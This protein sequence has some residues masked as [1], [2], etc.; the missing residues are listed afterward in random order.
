M[1]AKTVGQGEGRCGPG[2]AGRQSKTIV[3]T[4]RWYSLASAISDLRDSGC[5]LVASTTVRRPRASRLRKIA[6]SRAKASSV[7]DCSFSSSQTSERQKSEETTSV[8]RKCLRP[9][10][11]LAGVGWT[12]EEDQRKLRESYLHAV[13][14]CLA[15]AVTWVDAPY[16]GS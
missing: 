16:S 11:G 2:R 6:C 3:M 15:N 1:T 9:E 10:C 8:G 12:D 7:A 13:T 4:K 14:S 5:R